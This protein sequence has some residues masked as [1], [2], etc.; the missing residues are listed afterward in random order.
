MGTKDVRA[1]VI[2]AKSGA[3][4]SDVLDDVCSTVNGTLAIV[5]AIRAASAIRPHGWL[6]RRQPRRGSHD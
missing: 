1:Y 2:G 4:E 5:A 3:D 6:A